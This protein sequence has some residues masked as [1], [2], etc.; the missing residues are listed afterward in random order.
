MIKSSLCNYSDAYIFVKRAITVVG[1]EANAAAFAEDR[2]NKQITFKNHR[3][4]LAA[5]AKQIIPRWIMLKIL[6]LQ[7]QCII[8]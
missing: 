4:S 2:N 1:N 6:T 5:Q 7:C 3:N 8:Y